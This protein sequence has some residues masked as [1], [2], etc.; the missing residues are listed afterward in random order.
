MSI[1]T[2]EARVDIGSMDF[3]NQVV[4]KHPESAKNAQP[5]VRGKISVIAKNREIQFD[6]EY[7]DLEAMAQLI[8]VVKGD[9]A[10]SLAKAFVEGHPK[11]GRGL[12]PKQWNWVHKLVHDSHK[13]EMPSVLLGS[14]SDLSKLF[15]DAAKNIKYP[16]LSFQLP[17][18]RPLRLSRAGANSKFP[19]SINVTDGG[20]YGNNT[21]YGRIVGGEFQMSHNADNEVL[22]FL[23]G[24]AKDPTEFGK[25]YGKKSGCCCFCNKELTQVPS[26]EAGYGPTC[27]KNWSL[28]WGKSE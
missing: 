2:P 25:T 17:D 10:V 4:E 26:V 27:A 19:Y 28:P 11:W 8:A 16:K 6:S 9:F 24:L 1:A 5:G 12:S 21:W 7:T 3:V 18:G 15:D 20:S 22:E 13:P 14:A 23:K